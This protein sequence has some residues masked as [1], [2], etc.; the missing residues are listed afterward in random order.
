MTD[1]LW[2]HHYDASPYSEKVRLI[3]GFKGLRWHSVVMP[4][5]MPKPTLTALTGA[6]RGA[7]VLQV[8]ADIYIDSAL[9][10]AELERRHPTP[11]LHPESASKWATFNAAWA[12][13]WLFWKAAK[14]LTGLG[15]GRLPA[16]FMADR[17]IMFSSL[18]SSA[19]LTDELAHTQS[20]LKIALQQ[21]E[22]AL[23]SGAFVAGIEASYAD[24]ALVHIVQFIDRLD[25]PMIDPHRYPALRAWMARLGEFGHGERIEM[26]ASDALAAAHSDPAALMPTA[27]YLDPGGVHIGEQV[28]VRPES[29]GQ[30]ELR[31]E[32]IDIS[33]QRMV[34]ARDEPTLGRLYIHYPRLGYRIRRGSNA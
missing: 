17:Q 31:G 19:S 16:A 2:L 3:M 6:Y 29:F 5:I 30:E 34:I 22:Q 28:F 15:A 21:L 12:D 33:S 10:A 23:G 9:I 7:P 32:L 13:Q 20:Q 26:S 1:T 24:F 8:G 27:N 14:L 18:H 4:P 11:T 25:P